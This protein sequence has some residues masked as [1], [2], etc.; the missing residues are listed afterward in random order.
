MELLLVIAV[1][2]IVSGSFCSYLAKQKN[3]DAAAWFVLGFL[4]SIFALIAIAA[5]VQGEKSE[6]A[7][8]LHIITPEQARRDR[9]VFWITC[10]VFGSV[11][12]AFLLRLIA[13]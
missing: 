1:L 11:T 13:M 9:R 2:S 5:S 10:L 7:I 3:R 12:L 4:F 8:P 6:A